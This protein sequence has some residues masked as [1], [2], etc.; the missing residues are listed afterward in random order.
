MEIR[1]DLCLPHRI[2]VTGIFTHILV[3]VDGKSVSVRQYTMHLSYKV[4]KKTSY[5]GSYF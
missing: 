2:N 5:K 4:G 1:H 3:D